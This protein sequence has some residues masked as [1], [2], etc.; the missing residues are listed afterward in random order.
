M[1]HI[2][3]NKPYLTGRELVYI[4]D[5]IKA[6]NISGN[7][8]FTK[9]C[10]QFFEERF[11]F[12]RCLLTSSCTDALEMAAI[13]LRIEPGDEVIVPSFTFV[14]GANAFVL[15]GAKIV[16]ADS[17]PDHPNIDP[18]KLEQLITSK[19]KAI[20]PVHYAGVCCDMDAIMAIAKKHNLWVVED[21]AQCV[22]SFY[23]DRPAGSIG[24]LS[25]FSFHETKNI[26]SG[27]G[28]MLV[29]NDNQFADRA[30]IIWEKGTNR[31]AF[32]RGEIDKYNW[33][34]VGSS[35]LPSDM[36]A[37]FLFAQLEKLDELQE[38]RNSI[39]NYYN[40]GLKP[41]ADAGKFKVP[42]IPEYAQHNAHIF[43]LV[44]KSEEEQGN[45]LQHLRENSINAVFHYQQLH[46]SPYFI[47]HYNGP[48]LPNSKRFATC[49]VRLPF[50]YALTKAEQDE[51][52]R[53]VGSFYA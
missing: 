45:L 1:S 30:E 23:K 38:K 14:S 15:R 5:A 34:D 19:T 36:I 8:P 53:A 25:T 22:N 16:F 35:F 18:S 33:V 29:I 51:V 17:L 46:Q 4:A 7:G 2:P 32:W 24:H 12:N 9:K 48:E 11:G 13:L 3:F 20:V 37:A 31:A 50:F 21:A 44:C 39:W 41:L 6:S 42:V 27:E 49:L 43:Y 40:D 52:I 47:K 10:Q 28:G 26:I